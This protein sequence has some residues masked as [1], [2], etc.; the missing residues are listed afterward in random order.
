MVNRR[1]RYKSMIY[2]ACS[3]EE[4]KRRQFYAGVDCRCYLQLPPTPRTL[5]LAIFVATTT[6]KTDYFTPAAHARA[7]NNK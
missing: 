5:E 7:G 1:G 2:S 4:A 3:R 6:D